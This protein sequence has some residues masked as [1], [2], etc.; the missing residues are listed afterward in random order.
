MGL[1][2]AP[3]LGW[4]GYCDRPEEAWADCV[5]GTFTGLAA[6]SHG[7]PACSGASLDWAAAWLAEG[8]GAHPITG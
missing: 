2:G 6:P 1:K 7:L 8:P 5:G 3:R 4:R